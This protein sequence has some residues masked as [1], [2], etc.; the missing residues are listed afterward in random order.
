MRTLCTAAPLSRPPRPRSVDRTTRFPATPPSHPPSKSTA[1]CPWIMWRGRRTVI[2]AISTQPRP[3]P[4]HTMVSKRYIS[5]RLKNGFGRD[6]IGGTISDSNIRFLLGFNKL[7][8]LMSSILGTDSINRA[9][10]LQSSITLIFSFRMYSLQYLLR[11]L[12]SSNTVYN[13]PTL[14]HS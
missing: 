11:F 7:N 10:E 2:R 5:F 3:P 12:L 6:D 9:S 8:F 1:G 14:I 4:S 13:F